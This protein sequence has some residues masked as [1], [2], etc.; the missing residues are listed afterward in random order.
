MM[1]GLLGMLSVKMS[2]RCME[3]RKNGNF[4][5]CSWRFRRVLRKALFNGGFGCSN[6]WVFCDFRMGVT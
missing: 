5:V 4:R 3:V 1:W 2:K 6:Q